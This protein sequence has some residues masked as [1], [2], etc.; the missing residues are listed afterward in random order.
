[1]GGGAIITG[2]R[3]LSD[4]MIQAIGSLDGVVGLNL[5]NGFL[6]PEW[7]AVIFGKLLPY[8]IPGPPPVEAQMNF[9]TLDAVRAHAEHIADLI[10]WHRL[11]IGSDLD[12]GLGE[13]ETPVELRSAA[14]LHRIADVV[15]A[16]ARAG[17]LGG[18]WL[19]FL[20]EALPA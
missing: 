10:G 2:D 3:Q 12:G 11:G 19:R 14:D 17:V 5:F 6:V 20:A 8:V 7:E 9:V 1:M 16:E 15:P 18:N 13:D 4:E